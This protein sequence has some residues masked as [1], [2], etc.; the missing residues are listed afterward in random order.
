MP[1]M[2]DHFDI[3]DEVTDEK[4]FR[5]VAAPARQFLNSTFTELES[6][7]KREVEPVLLLH[8]DAMNDLGLK[9]GDLA[10][11]GNERGSVAVS[12]QTR[13]GMHAGTVVVESIWPN[14]AFNRGAAEKPIGINCLLSPDPAPPAGG[15]AIHDTSV[16]V[17]PCL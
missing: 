16:W 9:P 10:E 7:R 13:D 11:I 14:A 15:A 6:S 3:L 12:V 17:R 1:K 8:P 5:L 2:P 4:P